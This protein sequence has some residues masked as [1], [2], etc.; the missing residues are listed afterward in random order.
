MGNTGGKGP[1]RLFFGQLLTVLGILLALAGVIFI[2][3]VVTLAFLGIVLGTLG[4]VLGIR[5]LGIAAVVVSVLVLLFGLAAFGG[6]VPGLDPPGYSDQ[7]RSGTSDARS[8]HRECSS[9]LW[10]TL[11]ERSDNPFSAADMQQDLVPLL[12][13]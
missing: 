7:A 5:R 10:R 11:S 13:T 6:L 3:N 12:L 9:C 1:S 8:R 2:T 4:V